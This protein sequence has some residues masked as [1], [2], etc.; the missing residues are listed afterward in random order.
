MIA[1][2]T[3]LA[4]GRLA[5]SDWGANVAGALN[6]V[7]VIPLAVQIIAGYGLGTDVICANGLEIGASA[8]AGYIGAIVPCAVCYAACRAG[9]D[10]EQSKLGV[11]ARGALPV[12]WDA[13]VAVMA[14]SLA[15][16]TVPAL[17]A[18]PRLMAPYM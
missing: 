7:A 12:V 6:A 16:L 9:V 8:L 13:A 17:A 15:F 11:D 2:G 14:A 10:G 5:P 1:I 3:R 4:D 18:M